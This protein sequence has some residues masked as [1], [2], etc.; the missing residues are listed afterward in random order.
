MCLWRWCW[1]GAPGHP[2]PFHPIPSHPIPFHVPCG[3]KIPR[4]TK[5]E[6]WSSQGRRPSLLLFNKIHQDSV[7]LSEYITSAKITGQSQITLQTVTPPFK[8]IWE[9]PQTLTTDG[10]SNDRLFPSLSHPPPLAPPLLT[11]PSRDTSALLL[12]SFRAVIVS[13]L[14]GLVLFRC[15]QKCSQPCKKGDFGFSAWNI[16]KKIFRVLLQMWF[17]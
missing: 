10:I 15:S 14:S 8:A 7:S 1:W 5:G 6:M 2:I 11:Y 9:E 4:R 12:R 13:S 3:Y 17:I 16:G